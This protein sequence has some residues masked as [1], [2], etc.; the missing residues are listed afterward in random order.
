[1]RKHIEH[2]RRCQPLHQVGEGEAIVPTRLHSGGRHQGFDLARRPVQA[3]KQRRQRRAPLQVVGPLEDQHIGRPAPH[4]RVKG[5][6]SICAH[7]HRRKTEMQEAPAD[8][9]GFRLLGCQ[10]RRRLRH[11]VDTQHLSARRWGQP[12]P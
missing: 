11:L 5:A 6:E 8:D 3:L 12:R 10:Q 7:D 1:M 9:R 2:D 4:R